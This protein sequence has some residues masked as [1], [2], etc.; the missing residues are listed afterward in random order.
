MTS[1]I[2]LSPMKPSLMNEWLIES[3]YDNEWVPYF[4]TGVLTSM[5]LYSEIST[6]SEGE[7]ED[8]SEVL[9]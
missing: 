6:M 7:E 2:K 1:V 3:K 5:S 9:F 4:I 8:Q